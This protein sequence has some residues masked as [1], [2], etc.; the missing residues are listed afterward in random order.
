MK[1]IFR[2]ALLAFALIL[3]T[4][5]NGQEPATRGTIQETGGNIVVYH[6]TASWGQGYPFNEQ[7]WTSYNGTT[8]AKTG[9]VATAY[10]IVLRYH[11]YPTKGTENI[12]YNCQAPIYVEMTD[13]NY[14]WSNMPLV[15]DGNWNETQIYE[16]S[17][18]MAHLAHANFSSFG[19]SATTANEERETARLNRYFNYPKM[20]ASYQRD[21]TQEQWE[22][23]IKESL[24]NGCPVPYAANNSGTGDTRHMFVIDGYTDNGFF[25][26]NFGW[27][28]SGN[29][30]FK[31]NDITPYQ[32]DNYS[33]NGNSEHYANFNLKPDIARQTI[34]ASVAPT[35][36]GT[37]AINNNQAANE[38]TAELIEGSQATL[39]AKANDGYIF[40]HWSKGAE[41]ISTESTCKVTVDANDNDYVAN[42]IEYSGPTTAE[43]TISPTTGTL[44]NGTSKSSSWTFTKTSECPAELTLQSACG[45][46]A[47]NAMSINS[48]ILQLYAF[49]YDM[50][51]GITYT[52]GVPNGYLITGYELTYK[53]GSSYKITIE[54]ETMKQTATRSDQIFTATGLSTTNTSFNL[55]GTAANNFV[56]V[57]KFVV[58]VQKEGSPETSIKTIEIP[59]SESIYNLKGEKLDNITEPGIY[60]VNGKKILKK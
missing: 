24:D 9:C 37:V 2:T 60:I 44:T 13:R 18:L 42:F 35:N 52:L 6:E 54:N 23:K 39:T 26:F 33:W 20:A 38:V 3:S 57:T 17:K 55:T 45:T 46:T 53:M 32:G 5:V 34:T 48:G 30:W 14:D 22:A 10:A 19:S 43:Y 58:T 1:T 27:N 59:V 51:S 56:K 47:V 7:C 15:Y 40:S 36:A 21:Y 8:H 4:G 12:L 49:D 31:L 28:G 29:G 41:T 25:H 16:V 11:C 50:Q